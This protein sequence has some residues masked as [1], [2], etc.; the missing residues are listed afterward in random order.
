MSIIAIIPARMAS[1]RFPNK[2]LA[3]INGIPMIERVW[4]QAIKSN[5]GKVYVAC[6][7]KEVFELIGDVGG[8]AIMTDPN[9]PS[10]TDRIHSAIS[11]IQE[12][13]KIESIINLQ[14][15]MPL[16][17]PKD[18]LKVNEPIQNGYS[19]GTLATNL[20][21]KEEKNHN[22]TKVKIKWREEKHKGDAIDFYKKPKGILKNIYHHVGIYS[23]KPSTLNKFVNLPPSTNEKNLKLEQWRA[24][25]GGIKIGI[26]FV[27]NVPVSIDTKEDLIKIE[28]IIKNTNDKN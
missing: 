27:E 10:G 22:I 4:R 26:T 11:K 23:F 8:M 16:I 2:P 18:I 12:I 7:E 28:N 25:D 5:V 20:S 3:K 24:L 15:D 13:D 9:L 21:D 17:S 6:S 14:G 19:M 1:E